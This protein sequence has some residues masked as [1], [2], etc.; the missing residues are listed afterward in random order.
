MT[1]SRHRL[2]LLI[3]LALLVL[4]PLVVA[5][6]PTAVIAA[7]ASLAAWS[8][9]LE[10][11]GTLR[12]DESVTLSATERVYATVFNDVIPQ[13][14]ANA[15]DAVIVV[16]TN[17]VDIM[18]HLTARIAREHGVQP[19][20]VL[21]SGTTL[22]TA[23][24]R[25]LVGRQEIEPVKPKNPRTQP[26]T[27]PTKSR[28]YPYGVALSERPSAVISSLYRLPPRLTTS[29]RKEAASPLPTIIAS[30]PNSFHTPL[31]LRSISA[32]FSPATLPW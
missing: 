24:F 23:R 8:D 32:T 25:A 21:G 31:P 22:D 27:K 29:D 13:I 18:T 11:L 14:I 1:A 17:P 7:R 30:L 10:S 16:A 28:M 5:Q 20:R 3:G 12:A 2:P 19:S 6:Q 15:P 4:S 26:I 9:P